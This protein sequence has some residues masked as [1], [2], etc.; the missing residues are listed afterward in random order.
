MAIE[1]PTCLPRLSVDFVMCRCKPTKSHCWN[2]YLQ[3]FP[4]RK[5][6]EGSNGNLAVKDKY[7]KISDTCMFLLP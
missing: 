1:V 7:K 2:L 4:K 3:G 6:F 5:F